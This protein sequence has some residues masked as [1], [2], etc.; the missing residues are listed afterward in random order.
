MNAFEYLFFISSYI[1]IVPI[2]FYVIYFK[3]VNKEFNKVFIYVIFCFLLEL[4][5]NINRTYNLANLTFLLYLFVYFEATIFLYFFKKYL[6][7]TIFII[8]NSAILLLFVVFLAEFLFQYKSNI[9]IHFGAGR[10]ILLLISINVIL[11]GF[12]RKIDSWLRLLNYSLL[13][14]SLMGITIYS[15]TEFF[16][17]NKEYVMYYYTINAISN[18]LFYLLITLSILKCKNQ[19]SQV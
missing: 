11:T 12:N 19:Y 3:Y 18:I 1:C 17:I 2:C 6:D 7:K 16:I 5:L 4:V 10:I 15:F 14:Y 8:L 13:Q 9:N